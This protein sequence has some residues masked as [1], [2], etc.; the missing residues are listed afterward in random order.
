MIRRTSKKNP[1]PRHASDSA[2]HG[3]MVRRLLTL[4]SLLLC[5]LPLQAFDM[6]SDAPIS[7]KADSARLDDAAGKA[8]Y[9]GDVVVVQAETTLTAERVELYR[10][11][12]G[13]SRILAF[14]EPAHYQ[15]AATA[16]QPA[17]DGRAAE[18]EYESD[19]SVLILRK[20]AVIRQAGDIFRGN[21]IRYNTEARVVTAERG[22]NGDGERVEMVIQPRRSTTERGGSDG[23]AKS[24]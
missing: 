2:S 7:I 8:I 14:G 1:E 17:I 12:E 20:D 5:A 3:R 10:G 22:N 11:E 9:T 15:Q 18:I 24:E 16:E 19:A 21:L 4:G 13:V 23:A 6:E